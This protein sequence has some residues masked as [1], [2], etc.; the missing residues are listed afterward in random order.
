MSAQRTAVLAVLLA[1]CQVTA[2]EP[3]SVGAIE[4]RAP[5][6]PPLDPNRVPERLSIGFLPVVSEDEVRT[7]HQPLAEHLAE[8]LGTKVDVQ[9]SSTYDELIGMFADGRVDLV[10]LAPLSYVRAS[11]RISDVALIATNIAEGG[12]SY[13]AY[14]LS[15]RDREIRSIA[16]LRGQRLGFVDKTSTSGYLYPTAF[17]VERGFSIETD[18]KSSAFLGRHDVV[19][20]QIIAGDI[21]VGASYSGALL[22]AEE[23]GVDVRQLRVVAKTGRIPHD[24]WCAR[25]TL[26]PRLRGKI[27]AV[28]LSIST[29]D[30][31]GRR[32]LDALPSVNG[33]AP[34][35]DSDYDGV[36]RV[37]QH[38]DTGD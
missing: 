26:D 2:P 18:A 13:S 38:L 21:D 5:E 25:E 27:R 32:V 30:E 4:S 34:A 33:F 37:L 15:R 12:S 6:S 3:K 20:D 31:A 23:R 10:Q 17:L 11:E 36:R 1:S 7:R 22:E 24:A 14:L 8:A 29:R 28:L 16:D 9:V 19:L 35:V